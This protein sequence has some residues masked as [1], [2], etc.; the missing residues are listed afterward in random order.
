MKKNVL[1][2]FVTIVISSQALLFAADQPKPSA[3]AQTS[4]QTQA[5]PAQTVAAAQTPAQAA[6]PSQAQPKQENK[7]TMTMEEFVN[8]FNKGLSADKKLFDEFFSENYFSTN[9]EPFK[10]I[11][12]FR[13][14]MKEMIKDYDLNY[15][16]NMYN[17]WYKERLGSAEF[18]INTETKKDKTIVTIQIPGLDANN[19]D[20]NINDKRI[21]ISGSYSKANEVRDSKNNVVSTSQEYR[22]FSKILSVPGETVPGKAQI[23]VEKDVITITFP[24]AEKK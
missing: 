4:S 21:K 23:K 13:A 16:E 10:Q 2:A 15:F 7:K 17:E 1:F 3:Q 18:G 6:A 22:S 19:V 11:E 20:I 5:Q 14:M 8:E 24:K 9:P 12:N